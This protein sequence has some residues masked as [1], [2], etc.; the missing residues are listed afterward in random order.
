MAALGKAF[1]AT[2]HDT[3]QREYA[4][5]LPNGIFRLEIESS[6]VKPT[7]TGSGTFLATTVSVVEPEEFKG[8]KIFNNNYNLE[9]ANPKAQEIGQKQFA[10]LC[11]AI[12]IQSVED[13]EELHFHAF[14][15]KVGRGK[16]SVG[17]DGKSYPGRAE[18]KR[19]YFPDEEVPEIGIDEIQPAEEAPVAANDNKPAPVAA[20]TAAA[21]AAPAGRR[22]WGK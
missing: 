8:R 5:E 9:N 22:P 7:S 10:S 4:G 6:E 3:T 20:K 16:P 12:G 17:K 13:S 14:V 18:I 2:E 1:D 19:Y 11:R 21:S 15:A